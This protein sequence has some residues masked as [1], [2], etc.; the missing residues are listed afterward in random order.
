MLTFVI[1]R[2]IE[3]VPVML[4]VALIVYSLLLV[5]PG[6]PATTLAGDFA[7]PEN[8][9]AI[10][11]TLKLD[12]PF[13]IR[14]GAWLWGVLQGDLGRSMYSNVPVTTLIGQR[15]EPTLL[16]MA[17]TVLIT[18]LV[19]IPLGVVAARRQGTWIDHLISL[20]A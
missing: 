20:V 13:H 3:T 11:E 19:A 6:D 8:I 18:V 2:I 1:R 17:L 12:E 14:F 16:L 9:A 15:L 4:I 7:T 10:R 5:A